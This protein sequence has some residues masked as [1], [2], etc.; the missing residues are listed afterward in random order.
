MCTKEHMCN[1]KFVH[2]FFRALTGLKII[3]II[4]FNAGTNSFNNVILCLRGH[5]SS[6]WAIWWPLLTYA[7]IRI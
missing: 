7:H 3:V 5:K 2:N 1:L 4:A 6:L